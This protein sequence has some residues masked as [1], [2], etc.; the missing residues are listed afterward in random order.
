MQR[1]QRNSE[2]HKARCE[3]VRVVDEKHKKNTSR[4]AQLK[5]EGQKIDVFFN[6]S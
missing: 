5:I 2:G 4:E 1:I 6:R 3:E